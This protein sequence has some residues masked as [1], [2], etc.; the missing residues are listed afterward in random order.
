MKSNNNM[1]NLYNKNK[2]NFNNDFIDA[3]LKD[4]IKDDTLGE[5]HKEE[6][7]F[8][9]PENYFEKSKFEINSNISVKKDGFFE[10]TSNKLKFMLPIAAAIALLVT[11][12]IFKP[13][14]LSTIKQL[15]GIVL[16]T[17]DAI[18]TNE[19]IDNN[20]L[21]YDDISINSL[22]VADDEIDEYLED[23]ILQSLVEE[24]F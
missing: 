16:D 1:E 24:D 22:F 12:T 5:S 17:V 13:N 23:F 3:S 10:I 21:A 9:I 14:S 15:P 7:G 4:K 19:F 8:K 6:L 20:A 18:N 2:M 11:L